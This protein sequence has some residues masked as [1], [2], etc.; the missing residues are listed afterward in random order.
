MG[1][2]LPARQTE[3]DS[4]RRENEQECDE[5]DEEEDDRQEAGEENDDSYREKSSGVISGSICSDYY[6]F[7]PLTDKHDFDRPQNENEF[8]ILVHFLYLVSGAKRSASELLVG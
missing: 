1:G 3:S 4:R 5:S 6:N 8:A 7:N 2:E